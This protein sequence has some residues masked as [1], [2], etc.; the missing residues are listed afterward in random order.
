M[1]G[2]GRPFLVEVQNARTFPS[3]VL[4]K[5]IEMKINSLESKLVS[6]LYLVCCSLPYSACLCNDYIYTTC[7]GKGKES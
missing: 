1:L 3:D 2:T 6:P 5:E 4:I 7:A